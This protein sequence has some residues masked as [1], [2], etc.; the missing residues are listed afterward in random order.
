MND[1]GTEAIVDEQGNK[2]LHPYTVGK[3]VSADFTVP[4]VVDIHIEF[5]GD[6]RGR[7]FIDASLE[8]LKYGSIEI[9]AGKAHIIISGEKGLAWATAAAAALYSVLEAAGVVNVIEMV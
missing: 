2:K 6:T 4:R 3:L 8:A 1:Y 7:Y 9:W 5:T